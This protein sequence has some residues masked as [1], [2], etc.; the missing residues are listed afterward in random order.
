MMTSLRGCVLT[1]A[2]LLS[3]AVAAGE[4]RLRVEQPWIRAAPPG[5]MMLAGYVRLVN[6]GD[7]VVRI[8]GAGSSTFASVEIHRTVEEAGVAR[9][10]P[11]GVLEI[12][13]GASLELQPGGLHLMLM[14]P[15][16]EL[17][18]G[19][20]VVIDLLTDTDEPIPAVFT[21]RRSID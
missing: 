21:V 8:A 12:A 5:S 15:R 18:E 3:S 19:K 14:Q 4:T 10:R 7:Q 9:M 17:P 11:A 13:P 1:L 16:A 20:T 2:L 6:D